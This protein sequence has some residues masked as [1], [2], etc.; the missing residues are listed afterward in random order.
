MKNRLHSIFCV[1]GCLTIAHNSF[2]QKTGSKSVTITLP[3]VTLLDIEPAGN[4]SFSFVAPTE[5]GN[6]LKNPSPNTTKW[7]NYTSAI[8]TG[9]ST[10]IVTASVNN[11]IPGIDIK[12]L[13]GPATGVGAGTLG[14]SVGQ[15]TLSTTGKTIISGIGGAYTGNG[16]N[17]GH[18]LT[19]S[20]SANSS[21]Y[22]L[23][24]AQTNTQ[25][26]ITYTLSSN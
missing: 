22:S 24:K 5:A 11:T 4:I 23:I 21:D 10:K 1:L 12:L 15:I 19:I 6:A 20:L 26:I 2:C 18:Q 7:L 14:S 13:A 9:G 16:S 25:I 17:N 3:Q 8:P